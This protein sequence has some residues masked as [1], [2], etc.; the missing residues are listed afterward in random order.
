M[1]DDRSIA[2]LQAANPVASARPGASRT[3]ESEALL[4]RILYEPVHAEGSGRRPHS[5]RRLALGVVL[6]VAVLA[7]GALPASRLLGGWLPDG[8]TAAAATPDLLAVAHAPQQPGAAAELR[9]IAD[10]VES[11]ADDVGSGPGVEINYRTWSLFTRIDD[12]DVR[13]RV[14]PEEITRVLDA[15]G[16]GTITTR[17]TEDDGSQRE[18]TTEI[19][20]DPVEELPTSLEQMR[21]VLGERNP[22][23]AGGRFNA[24]VETLLERPAGPASRAAILRYLAET[25]GVASVGE[26]EDRLGRTGTGFTV[27]SDASGLPTRYLLVVDPRS[28]VVLGYEE[29]LTSDAGRLEVPIPSVIQYIVWKNASYTGGR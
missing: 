23:G 19:R 18:T 26:V 10:R 6:A 9:E 1:T 20:E 12:V 29:M 7:V 11:R 5:G 24:V 13:S 2:L 14:V 17:L 22:S 21:T 27:E 8:A 25:R 28:G 15:D 16:F 4:E 3:A